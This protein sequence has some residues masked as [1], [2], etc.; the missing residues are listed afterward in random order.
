MKYPIVQQLPVVNEISILDLGSTYTYTLKNV[1]KPGQ[2][3]WCGGFQNTVCFNWASHVLKN[4]V[5]FFTL[6]LKSLC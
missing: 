3:V 6:C 5:K 1:T 4:I 2:K